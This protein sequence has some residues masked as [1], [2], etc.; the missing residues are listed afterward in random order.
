MFNP[1]LNVTLLTLAFLLWRP[2]TLAPLPGTAHCLAPGLCVWVALAVCE[3][4]V[5]E[6]ESGRS[7][8]CLLDQH[9]FDCGNSPIRLRAWNFDCFLNAH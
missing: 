9:F 4:L 5:M 8:E 7:S 3:A 6:E 2:G 1:S